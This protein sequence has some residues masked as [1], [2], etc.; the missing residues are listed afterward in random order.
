MPEPDPTT[1]PAD[2]PAE[3]ENRLRVVV[4]R[5][6][7][8][9]GLVRTWVAEAS[10]GEDGLRALVHR[11]PWDA[12]P[13]SFAAPASAP[14]APADDPGPHPS[15]APGSPQDSPRR[16]APSGG[17]DR[18]RWDLS[19]EEA[20]RRERAALADEQVEGPWRELVDAVRSLGRAAAPGAGPDDPPR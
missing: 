14:A 13:D 8:I 11:C 6:G 3:S 17:A 7:G 9:A 5:S 20:N 12:V 1:V 2:D 16:G 15:A 19:V 10:S 18:F 4:R